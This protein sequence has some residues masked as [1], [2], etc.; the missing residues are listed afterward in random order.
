MRKL[1][2]KTMIFILFSD[3]ATASSP[4]CKSLG[5]N[6]EDTVNI[7]LTFSGYD[8]ANDLPG[9]NKDASNLD[10]IGKNV[11]NKQLNINSINYGNKR[12][13]LNNIK[14]AVARK[15]SV[16]FNFAGHGLLDLTEKKSHIVLP[17]IPTSCFAQTKLKGRGLAAVVP[18]CY[19]K[20]SDGTCILEADPSLARVNAQNCMDYIITSEDLKEIFGSRKVFG[21][22][23]SCHSGGFDLG[24]NSSMINS[25]RKHETANDGGGDGGLLISEFSRHAV[26]PKCHADS[27]NSK[28]I[29]MYEAFASINP[30]KFPLS[31]DRGF[32][33]KNNKLNTE[34]R[35][36]LDGEHTN[37][38][39]NMNKKNSWLHCVKVSKVPKGS[40][41]PQN[42]YFKR[43]RRVKRSGG[44]RNSTYPE[45]DP[46][47]DIKKGD[48]INTTGRYSSNGW[49]EV[50]VNYSSNDKCSGK[51][52]WVPEAFLQA[53]D[54]KDLELRKILN[55]SQKTPAVLKTETSID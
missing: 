40:S 44:L 37:Q 55:G 54:K 36:R 13:I 2:I 1:I 33:A 14:A 15:K 46:I 22:N 19:K 32:V 39:H 11:A 35:G 18:I 10:K 52:G 8:N 21:L 3:I 25:T 16:F 20:N 50:N 6:K 9:V 30:A 24:P 48:Q 38:L 17:S 23:D 7:N 42:D 29:D 43:F 51:S 41:C 34:Y 5:I 31:I 26:S 12:Q 27:D 4:W 49:V 45:D 47:C 53:K 28:D